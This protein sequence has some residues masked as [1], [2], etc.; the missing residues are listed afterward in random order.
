[1]NNKLDVAVFYYK[2]YKDNMGGKITKQLIEYI[3][4]KIKDCIDV[5]DWKQL[6]GKTDT[7]KIDN[8]I[9]VMEGRIC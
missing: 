3:T 7:D 9:Q 6:E 5:D 8:I 2:L 4:L 1:M